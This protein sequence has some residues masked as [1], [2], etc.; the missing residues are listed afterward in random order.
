MR[1]EQILQRPGP[2]VANSPQPGGCKFPEP[3]PDLEP[4]NCLATAQ[5]CSATAQPLFTTASLLLHH[6][7]TRHVLSQ[8]H[9]CKSRLPG[10]MTLPARLYPRS[11]SPC[12]FA[13]V[14]SQQEAEGFFCWI[15]SAFIRFPVNSEE[16]FQAEIHVFDIECL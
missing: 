6:C 7:F 4:Y 15:V 3:A 11:I 13:F 14:F 12:A 9:N 16:F 5:P 1:S 10:R 8:F 2:Q